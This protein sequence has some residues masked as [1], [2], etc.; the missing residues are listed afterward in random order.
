MQSIEDFYEHE[1]KDQFNKTQYR[2][3]LRKRKQNDVMED[4]IYYEEEFDETFIDEEHFKKWYINIIN[5]NYNTNFTTYNEAKRYQKTEGWKK[6]NNK[7]T[8]NQYGL[9]KEENELF[10]E[11]LKAG[12]IKLAKKYHPDKNGDTEKMQ[13]LN[14]LKEKLKNI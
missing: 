14:S 2:I 5:H 8:S 11:V 9:T 3:Y 7:D 1:F 10:K 6:S 4:M 12:F 13:L